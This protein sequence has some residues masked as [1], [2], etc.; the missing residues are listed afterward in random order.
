MSKRKFWPLDYDSEDDIF[1][2]VAWGLPGFRAS[3]AVKTGT[4][5]VPQAKTRD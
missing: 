1:D 5:R 2:N 3:R 4:R